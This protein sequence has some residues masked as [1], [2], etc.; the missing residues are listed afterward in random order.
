MSRVCSP[1]A[2]AGFRREKAANIRRHIVLIEKLKPKIESSARW[3][4]DALIVEDALRGGIHP[5]TAKPQIEK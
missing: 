3:M 4:T 1:I 5:N 2:G